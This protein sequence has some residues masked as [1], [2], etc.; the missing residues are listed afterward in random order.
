MVREVHTPLQSGQ[1]GAHTTTEWSEKVHTP[2]QSGQRSER[3]THHYRV[4]REV[5]TPLQSGQRG[6][7]ITTEWS[8]RLI[9][10]QAVGVY[11]SFE[12]K[13]QPKLS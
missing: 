6:A 10:L 7:H 5:H 12:L 1:R 13:G 3:C 2:L 9:H 4:V 11:I 8:E